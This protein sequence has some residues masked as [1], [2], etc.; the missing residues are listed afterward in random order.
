MKLRQTII[1]IALVCGLAFLPL[2]SEAQWRS[3]IVNTTISATYLPNRSLL[4]N[5]NADPNGLAAECTNDASRCAQQEFVSAN[6]CINTPDV[7]DDGCARGKCNNSSE[8]RDFGYRGGSA[9]CLTRT[10][11]AGERIMITGE[12]F[13]EVLDKVDLKKFPLNAFFGSCVDPNDPNV[14]MTCR[15]ID[16]R[17]QFQIAKGVFEELAPFNMTRTRPGVRNPSHY[18]ARTKGYHVLTDGLSS[19]DTVVV[20]ILNCRCDDVIDEYRDAHKG[21]IVGSCADNPEHAVEIILSDAADV[22]KVLASESVGV[23]CQRAFNLLKTFPYFLEDYPQYKDKAGLQLTIAAPAGVPIEG[24]V[25]ESTGG[26]RKVFPMTQVGEVATG[27]KS[28]GSYSVK[29]TDPEA[30]IDDDVP[31]VCPKSGIYGHD[32][33][34][35]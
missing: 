33:D 11:E 35:D 23:V 31:T 32:G 14:S 24:S 12:D 9:A 22:N 27:I 16:V 29:W 3:G 4:G 18:A 19:F 1:G 13:E 26:Q 25:L 17:T 7:R 20:D 10:L 30:W 34:C 21:H 6:Y 2:Q 15:E 5:N 8:E 28:V